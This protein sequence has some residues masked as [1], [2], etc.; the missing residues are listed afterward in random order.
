MIVAIIEFTLKPGVG[1]E[2]RAALEDMLARVERFEGYLGEEPCRSTADEHKFVTVSCWRDLAALEAWRE[3]PEHRRIQRLGREKFFSWY[4][5][6]I[7]R[8]EREYAWPAQPG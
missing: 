8:I 2:F 3:D 4:R 5:V 6:R 1:A 7:C